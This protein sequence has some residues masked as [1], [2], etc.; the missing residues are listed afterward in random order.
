VLGHQ[1]GYRF[2][3]NQ[4]AIFNPEIGKEFAQHNSV[5]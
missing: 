5:V 4:N 1:H 3:L 2:E